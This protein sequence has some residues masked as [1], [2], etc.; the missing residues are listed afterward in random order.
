MRRASF[1]AL[2]AGLLSCAAAAQPSGPAAASPEPGAF[3][4][5]RLEGEAIDGYT[6]RLPDGYDPRK[7]YPLLLSLHSSGQV[8]GPIED[9]LFHGPGS[10][11]RRLDDPRLDT[12]RRGFILVSPHL[13]DGP[14][15]ERQWFDRLELLDAILLATARSYRLDLSRVYLVGY[16]TGGTGTWGYAS[17][18]PGLF[19]ALIPIAGF[20]RPDLG[21][22]KPIVED[23]A[24]LGKPAIWAFYNVSDR[25][26]GYSHCRAAIAAIERLGGEPFHVLIHSLTGP[27][28]FRGSIVVETPPAE[29]LGRRRI[30]S[31]YRIGIHSE[32]RIWDNPVLYD[33]LLG[34]VNEG[35]REGWLYA[36]LGGEAY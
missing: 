30:L 29:L 12:L 10:A 20:T 9:A 24:P 17:R 2:L 28:E 36:A 6:I 35:Y 31:N 23:W 18:R 27:D 5:F 16:S 14:Y 25:A 3:A 19:A 11:I 4:A 8:G 1:A 32:G 13:S 22:K 21:I 34:Q 33:W 15:A 7:A 26:V